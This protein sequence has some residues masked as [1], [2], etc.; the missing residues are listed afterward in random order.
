MLLKRVELSGFKSFADKTAFHFGNGLTA[1]IGPNGSGKSNFVDAVKWVLGEQRIK[2]LRAD[3]SIDVIFSG[4]DKRRALSCAEVS[5]VLDN[6]LRTFGGDNDEAVISRRIYRDATSEY[7]L[8]GKRVR[9]RDVRDAITGCGL[10]VNEYSIIEQGKVDALIQLSPTDRR[11]LFD[12]A[13]GILKYKERRNEALRRLEKVTANLE[14]LSDIIGEVSKQRQS[15]MA[16]ASRARKFLALSEQLDRARLDLHVVRYRALSSVLQQTETALVRVEGKYATLLADYGRMN[17]QREEAAKRCASFRE[18]ADASRAETIRLEGL[19]SK[20][21]NELI[22]CDKRNLELESRKTAAEEDRKSL[23]SKVEALKVSL[24]KLEQEKAVLEKERLD[25]VAIAEEIHK[26]ILKLEPKIGELRSELRNVEAGRE[27]MRAREAE[28]A[29][30]VSRLSARLDMLSEKRQWARDEIHK[31]SERQQGIVNEIAN[32]ESVLRSLSEELRE[33]SESEKSLTRAL[34][35]I[36]KELAEKKALS[37]RLNADKAIVGR[38]LDYL[39]SLEVTPSNDKES[40]RKLADGLSVSEGWELAA[41]TLFG[42]FLTSPVVE[43]TGY[44]NMKTAVFLS[45]SD[46]PRIPRS[47]PGAVA[48]SAAITCPAD[49]KGA[50]AEFCEGV[51]FV[52][53][54]ESF[55]RPA[56]GTVLIDKRGRLATRYR[57][58]VPEAK[59]VSESSMLLR[60]VELSKLRD[61]LSELKESSERLR[62][63][64]AALELKRTECLKNLAELSKRRRRADVN[65]QLRNDRKAS[66]RHEQASLRSAREELE[67][68]LEQLE[69]DAASC[70]KELE[71]KKVCEHEQQLP[72]N[73]GDALIALRQSLGSLQRDREAMMGRLSDARVALATAQERLASVASRITACRTDIEDTRTRIASRESEIEKLKSELLSNRDRRQEVVEHIAEVNSGL[74]AAKTQFLKAIESASQADEVLKAVDAQLSAVSKQMDALRNE[75]EALMVSRSELSGK[76]GALCERCEEEM[77]IPLEE[78]SKSRIV[79]LEDEDALLEEVADCEKKIAPLKNVNLEA[80]KLLD[81]VEER[82]DFLNKQQ[83]DLVESR[84]ALEGLIVE[85]NDKC[86][87][88]FLSTFESTKRNF[89]DIFRKLFGGGKADV[90]LLEGD[91]L[92]AGVDISV[93]PPGK[94]PKTVSLL[95]GGEKT[96]T[97][98]A[99]LLAM[100]RANPSPFCILDEVDA[101][102]DEGNIERFVMLLREFTDRSQFILVSHNKRTIERVDDIFGVTV[103]S[104]GASQVLSVKLE[105]ADALLGAA[106]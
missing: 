4:N 77:G 20:H 34:A 60:R 62:D 83:K 53:D 63:S 70:T 13:A 76:I 89:N 14:R 69:R 75:R 93:R 50:V 27:E 58:F 79:A 25:R 33:A 17:V 81:E 44:G 97:A 66:F 37:D 29:K 106:N 23:E 48:A 10:G 2:T 85:I 42:E 40:T 99:L 54:I 43:R 26:A 82:F 36:D 57:L 7:L 80:V 104:D 90:I 95:S 98:I 1:I 87:E 24:E 9:L 64:I 73:L 6:S 19:L 31:I 15:L 51:F 55:E 45:G 38:R 5:L 30:E 72:D 86:K 11:A 32:V 41:E 67:R 22:W 18:A 78:E 21:E 59:A 65:I 102:L 56:H 100:F 88:L 49:L 61:S 52:E 46:I 3:E 71:S 92:E 105:K 101:P 12:E 94:D 91:V 68:R 103:G 16:Q 96:L 39:L 84:R 35:D 74:K 28:R 8:N 47:L